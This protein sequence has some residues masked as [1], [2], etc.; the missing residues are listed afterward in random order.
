MES[1][2]ITIFV[3]VLRVQR[4]KST[5]LLET[6]RYGKIRSPYR[7]FSHNN[8]AAIFVYK[9]INRWPCLCTKTINPEGIELFSHVK[10]F[11]YSKQFA[12]LLTT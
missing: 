8:A 6:I 7:S 5:V 10:T 4:W 1:G 2:V 12:K 11:F 9:A 3:M